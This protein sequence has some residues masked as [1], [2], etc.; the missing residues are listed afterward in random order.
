[1]RSSFNIQRQIDTPDAFSHVAMT[2]AWLK[3]K[4]IDDHTVWIKIGEPNGDFHLPSD[5]GN[6]LRIKSVRRPGAR[7]DRPSTENPVGTGAFMFKSHEPQSEI[8][9]VAKSELLARRAA[10]R[11]S[12]HSYSRG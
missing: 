8:Q 2:V 10:A 9:Y 4:R 11:W 5:G 6:R 12:H 1:M 7:T 3:W